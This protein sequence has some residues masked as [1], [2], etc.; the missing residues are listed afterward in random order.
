[1]SCPIGVPT[2]SHSGE[3]QRRICRQLDDYRFEGALRD[4]LRLVAASGRVLHKPG[5]PWAKSGG[6]A[7]AGSDSNASGQT[8]EDLAGRCLV[9]FAAPAGW[10]LKQNE[11]Q[12]RLALDTGKGCAGG[13]NSVISRST[14][15][16]S[17]RLS[18]D[19]FA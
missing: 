17:K 14:S 1:M 2:R 4:D 8:E 16:V 12:R 9:T 13:A 19:S 11:A 6:I 10:Q 7:C 5:V 18:P 3:R 15:N